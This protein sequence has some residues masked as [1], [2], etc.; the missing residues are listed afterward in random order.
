MTVG[1]PQ[2]KATLD[3]RAGSVALSLRD[4]FLQIQNL[5]AF[6]GAKTDPELAALG[7]SAPEITLLRASFTDLNA[8]RLV[9]TGAATQGALNNF[10]F[11]SNKIVG[12]Y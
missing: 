12:P 11:N 3:N 9:A 10:L 2:D 8:L 4:I 7:Y 1:F 5:N 6:L